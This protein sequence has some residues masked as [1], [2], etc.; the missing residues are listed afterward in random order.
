MVLSHLLLNLFEKKLTLQ[1]E[2]GLAKTVSLPYKHHDHILGAYHYGNEHHDCGN[3]QCGNSNQCIPPE[4]F[5]SV[6]GIERQQVEC[7]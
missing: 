2:T 5:G 7:G 6:Q 3:Q 1:V 4:D